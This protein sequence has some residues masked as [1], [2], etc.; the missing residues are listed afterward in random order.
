MLS[1][2]TENEHE[3]YGISIYQLAAAVEAR[4]RAAGAPSETAAFPTTCLNF[5][6]MKCSDSKRLRTRKPNHYT[7]RST[8]TYDPLCILKMFLTNDIVQLIWLNEN[9]YAYKV[10]RSGKTMSSYDRCRYLLLYW[11]IFV[12]GGLQMTSHRILLGFQPF[13]VII[14]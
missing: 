3:F 9:N 4:K 10:G 7:L 6:P 13:D 5:N 14:K 1:D 2:L 11:T 12:H 8:F